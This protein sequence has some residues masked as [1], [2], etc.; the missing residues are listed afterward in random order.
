MSVAAKDD[1]NRTIDCVVVRFGLR[2]L[3]VEGSKIL[4]NDVPIKIKGVNR[5]ESKTRGNVFSM[6]DLRADVKALKSLDANFVRGA[7]YAQDSRFLELCDEHGIMVWEEVLGWQNTMSDLANPVFWNH[8]LDAAKRMVDAHIHHPSIILWGFLNEF[9]EARDPNSTPYFAEI[10]GLFRKVD[11]SRLITWG[12]S[13]TVNDVNLH[14]ADV[15]SFHAYNGWYPTSDPLSL[16]EVASISSVWKMLSDW[17]RDTHGKPLLASEAGAGAMYGLHGPSNGAK[18]SEEV[19]SVLVQL[20]VLSTLYNPDMCGIA[21]WQFADSL[22][23]SRF[24]EEEA[25]PRGLN[26]KGLM[27]LDRQP[28]LS[29]HTVSMLFRG[30][31]GLILPDE[32]RQN[33]STADY[34]NAVLRR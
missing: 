16:D 4:L 12:S 5:H 25:R 10:V 27:G 6:E 11:N 9:F 30:A 31:T 34:W 33:S 1:S 28:K 8:T 13:A 18:W 17:V 23:D 32:E 24:I 26:N 20:H 14:L 15:L 2:T 19:Q 7:H 21:I 22:I 29:F 3:R